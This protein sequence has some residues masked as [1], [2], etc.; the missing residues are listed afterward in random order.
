MKFK[1]L[2]RKVTKTTTVSEHSNINK[3]LFKKSV[4]VVNLQLTTFPL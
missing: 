3:K 4:K 1:G 2:N